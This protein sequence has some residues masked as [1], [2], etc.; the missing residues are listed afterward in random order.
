MNLNFSFRA[1]LQLFYGIMSTIILVLASILIFYLFYDTINK[2]CS[3]H[4]TE[5]LDLFVNQSKAEKGNFSAAFIGY[6]L[7]TEGLN[8]EIIK[9]A[10]ASGKIVFN[11]DEFSHPAL[12]KVKRSKIDTTASLTRQSLSKSIEIEGKSYTVNISAKSKL[13]E[14][15]L[16]DLILILVGVF[17]FMLII[18]TT[19]SWILIKKALSPLTKVIDKITTITGNNLGIRLEN[20]QNNDELGKLTKVFNEM[21]SRLQDSFELQRGFVANAAHELRTPLTA[22]NGQI[23]VALLK[24]RTLDDYQKT[25]NSIKEDINWLT[26]LA[27]NILDLLLASLDTNGIRFAPLR[28]DE[29]LW[30]ARVDLGKSRPGHDVGI[31]YDDLPENEEEIIV[32]GN[33]QLLKTAFINIMSNACKFSIDQNVDVT[34]KGEKNYV[35]IDFIDRGIGIEKEEIKKILEPFYRA[36]NAR[37]V[38][39]HGLG[40]PLVARIMQQ[41]KGRMNIVSEAGNGTIVTLYIPIASIFTQLP[42]IYEENK[43]SPSLK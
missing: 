33:E 31:N 3:Y 26:E 6:K 15:A 13:G 20:N 40:L 28:I 38:K 7:V 37:H 36:N 8:H 9:V 30:Q 32:M 25:L 22:I 14:K 34:L 4:L 21:L 27:N 1:R 2:D 11:N 10:D 42:S 17:S 23:E 41:H 35:V 12:S 18:S 16:T 43:S 29:V 19:V 39:G 24:P 5:S